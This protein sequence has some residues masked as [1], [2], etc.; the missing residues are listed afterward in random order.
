MGLR[1]DLPTQ[2]SNIS[3]RIFHVRLGKARVMMEEN[4][5]WDGA[6]FGIKE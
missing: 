5:D 4:Q 3:H 6:H 1:V 2:Q